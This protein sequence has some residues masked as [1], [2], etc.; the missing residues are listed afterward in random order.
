RPHNLLLAWIISDRQLVVPW[1]INELA[2]GPT[3]Q[4]SEQ[5]N[6]Q[7]ARH[8]AHAAVVLLQV[9]QADGHLAPHDLVYGNHLWPLLRQGSD[10]RVRSYR[11]HRLGRVGVN[12]ETLLQQLDVERDVE[13]RRA[14][15][16]SLGEFA[17]QKLPAEQRRTRATQLLR[18][19]RN[20]PD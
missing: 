12:P 18:L 1:M 6:D 16:L 10:L 3:A 4:A 11:M 19:Y 9:D 5:E 13:V 20:D 8:Q 2:K 7:R 17:E 14:L 15:L